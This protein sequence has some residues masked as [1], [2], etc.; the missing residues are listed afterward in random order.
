MILVFVNGFLFVTQRFT[1]KALRTTEYY[2]IILLANLRIFVQI[3]TKFSV[4]RLFPYLMC[5]NEK[6]FTAKARRRKKNLLL[7]KEGIHRYI[8]KY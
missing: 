1:E 5:W 7:I 6:T 4:F 8:Y 3:R 2:I